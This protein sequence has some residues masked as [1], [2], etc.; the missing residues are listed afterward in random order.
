MEQ[1]DVKTKAVKGFA[2]QLLQNGA[3][4]I[5]KFAV[6][7]VIARHI[8]PDEYGVVGMVNTFIN[9]AMVFVINGFSTAVIQKDKIEEKDLSTL[10]YSSVVL[11][12]ILYGILFAAAPAIARFY[13]LPILLI[14]TRVNALIIVIGMLYNVQTALVMRNMQFDIS[15]RTNLIGAIVQGIVGIAMAYHGYGVWALVIS[16]IVN[17]LTC[18]VLMWIW[19]SWKPKLLFSFEALKENLPFSLK[20]LGTNLSDAVFNNFMSLIIGKVYS[21]EALAYYNKGYQFPTLVMSMVDGASNNVM[22]SALSKFQDDWDRGVNALR[23]EIQ[24]VMFVTAPMM[25]GL[26]GAADTFVRLLLTDK[27]AGAIPYV[28]LGC[29]ICIF[30]PF[31]VKI[32][33][34]N[35]IGKSGISFIVKIVNNTITLVL[36]LLTYHISVYAMVFSNIIANLIN[37]TIM[38][39]VARKHLNYGILDQI[40]DAL[41][42]IS[43]AA[44]MGISVQCI[45]SV[46]PLPLV[47]RFLIQ[48]VAG[49]AIYV[50]LTWLFNRKTLQTTLQY[51]KVFTS[52]NAN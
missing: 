6:S 27:W 25:F 43:F 39:F 1:K 40:K 38:T 3:G 10:F 48:V 30:W 32:H 11:G 16:S 26:F 50:L 33:A 2:W 44:L 20:V 45:G 37:N 8:T 13:N 19:V 34:L 46:L 49:V 18:A 47:I 4:Y 51:L 9:I 5:T 12:L 35:S 24:M 31:S 14:L 17:Y 23:T 52:H 36:V 21:S 22:F 42:S 28:R 15:F 29:M 7:V 41:S